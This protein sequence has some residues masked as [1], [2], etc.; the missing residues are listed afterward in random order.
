MYWKSLCAQLDYTEARVIK[1]TLK[2][3]VFF[4][5]SECAL[6][7]ARTYVILVLT[8]IL[9]IFPLMKDPSG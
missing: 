7:G 8:I 3:A 2:Y 5:P 6:L 9:V 1:V 4:P